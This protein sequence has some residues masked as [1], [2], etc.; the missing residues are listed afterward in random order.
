[1][2]RRRLVKLAAA[3]TLLLPI[4][5]VAYPTPGKPQGLVSDFANVLKA[6]ER[7]ALEA[8]LQ[9]LQRSSGSQV[10]VVTVPSLG[11]DTVENYAVELFKDWG[12]GQQGRDNGVLILAAVEDR[13]VR[14]EV[15]YGLEGALTD[16]ESA[17]II[18]D[19]ITPAFK[20]G[21][22]AEGLSGAADRVAAALAGE[23]P[24]PDQADGSS[25]MKFNFDIIWF[26]FFLPMW[27]GS[28]L[29]R[30]KSWWAGGIIGG[31]A[32]VVLGFIFGFL[33]YGLAAVALL[34]P[35]GL[36]FDFFVSRSYQQGKATGHF[37]WWIGGGR[38]GSGGS[39][40]GGGFGGFSGGSSGGG[41]ASGR[42]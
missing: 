39:F 40:G 42:W 10:A 18:R 17:R 30:S 21:S 36:L 8:K 7:Q 23:A 20:N 38:G 33:Y 28:V 25:G 32:G 5:A 35:I 31:L 27:L 3:F 37:P 1:M 29:G 11:G 41:G 24:P 13:Q 14:I 9:A 6:E 19:I 26:L 4:A 15:G 16:A 34:V 22:Y 2:L 12:I